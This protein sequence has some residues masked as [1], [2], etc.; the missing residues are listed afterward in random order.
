MDMAKKFKFSLEA[1]LRIR[2]QIVE[3]RKI[4]L[5]KAIQLK[6]KRLDDVLLIEESNQKNNEGFPS[7]GSAIY[8]IAYQD[9]KKRLLKEKNDI[10]EELKKINEVVDARRK[11]L[12]L[13]MEDEKIIEKLKEKKLQEYN[14]NSPCIWY[15]AILSTT[16]RHG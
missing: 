8:A 3:T 13:A 11:T 16:N 1:L 12:N 6:E 2:S 4:E 7:S 5:G 9:H 14:S 15:N 10:Q